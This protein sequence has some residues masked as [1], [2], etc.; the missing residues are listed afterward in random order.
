MWMWRSYYTLHEEWERRVSHAEGKWHAKLLKREPRKPLRDGLARK[1]PIRIDLRTGSVEGAKRIRLSSFVLR[2]SSLSRNARI[3]IPLSLARYHLELLRKGRAI[4]FQLVKRDGKY[5]AH[6]CVKYVVPD[7]PVGAVRG[8]DL[9]VR[10]SMATVLLSVDRPLRRDDLTILR[11][12]T[13]KHRLGMLNRRVAELQQARKWERL[14]CMRSKRRHVSEYCDRLDAI[15]IAKTCLQERSMVVVGYPKNIK[16]QN[17]RGNGKRK[18]RQILQHRFTYGRRI[19]YISEESVER[20]VPVRI[21]L[22]AW[23]SKRCHRCN[24]IDTRRMGQ[25]LLLCLNC[26]LQYNVDWNGAINIGSAFL[27][28]TLGRR[29]TAGLAHAGD[30][31]A[32][33][34]ASPE[35]ENV[36]PRISL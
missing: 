21:T 28:A 15:R 24:S 4:D 27:P 7:V 18:L 17:Y 9:G 30:E 29:A 3:T 23:T 26:G 32:H 33:K 22:E 12:G 11:D 31:L 35:A 19:R 16:Y 20:G 13:K 36:H 34:P 1:I 14:I 10:R 25:S 8:I 5:F 6:V 2:L